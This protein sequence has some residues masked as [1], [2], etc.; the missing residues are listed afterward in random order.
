M[1]YYD[2]TEK[3]LEIHTK[4]GENS[5]KLKIKRI[6][7]KVSAHSYILIPKNRLRY[8]QSNEMTTRVVF[9]FF[10]LP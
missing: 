6:A 4:R 5:E 7:V 3:C 2:T 10:L 8:E 1:R 9:F